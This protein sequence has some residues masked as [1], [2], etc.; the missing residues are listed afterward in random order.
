MGRFG[1]KIAM[2]LISM[3]S[4]TQNKLKMLIINTLIGID[5]IDQNYKFAKFGP[6]SERCH[7]FYEIWPLEQMG[8]M[9]IINKILGTDDIDPKL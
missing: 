5:D 1:L 2:C 3:K 6:K 7:K 4:D 8:N 9:L